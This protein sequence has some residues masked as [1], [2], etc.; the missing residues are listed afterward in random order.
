MFCPAT[1]DTTTGLDNEI[2]LV[3]GICT[4]GHLMNER[5][6]LNSGIIFDPRKYF[7]LQKNYFENIFVY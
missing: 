7:G 1:S 5:F 3:V 2:I 6:G 4:K